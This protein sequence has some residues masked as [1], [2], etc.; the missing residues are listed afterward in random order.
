VKVETRSVS[1]I[2]TA[3]TP[4]STVVGAFADHSK[5][6]IFFSSTNRDGIA[7]AESANGQDFKISKSKMKLQ[8]FRRIH[9]STLDIGRI[10]I[11]ELKTGGLKI[12]VTKDLKKWTTLCRLEEPIASSGVVVSEFQ[13]NSC[14]L[15]YLGG[16]AIRIAT[17]PDAKSW[18][19]DTYPTVDIQ[20]KNNERI[21]IDFAEKL[22][23]GILV[24]YRLISYSNADTEKLQHQV[25]LVLLDS[26]FP[27]QI[28]WHSIQPI[29]ENNHHKSIISGSVIFRSQLYGFWNHTEVGVDLVRYQTENLPFELPRDRLVSLAKARSN[30]ILYPRENYRWESFATYNPAA[31]QIN[32]K[33]HILYRAQGHDLISSIGYASSSDGVQIDERLSTPV[34]YP[35]EVFESFQKLSSTDA[36]KKF[37]SGGGIAGCEDPRVSVIDNRVYMTYVAFDGASPPRIALTSIQL[38]DF[39][40]KRWLWKKPVL[41]SPP[42]VVDK[43]A[44]IFPEK[45]RGK[46]VIMHRI[47]PNIL[48]DYVSDLNFDGSYWLKEQDHIPIREG[49][50]DSRKVGAGAPPIKTPEGWLLIYYGVDDRDDRFYKMGAMLLD[51]ENPAKVLYRSSTPIL[52]PEEWYE[53]SGFKPG[54]VYPCGAVVLKE[55][56]LVYYGGADCVVCVASADLTEFIMALKANQEFKLHGLKTQRIQNHA[57]HQI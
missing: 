40:D 4:T 28:V 9:F 1:K 46:Y 16:T 27:N 55:K 52:E 30:P 20:V 39:L 51:L 22:P 12:S 53:N 42:G 48:I 8:S 31:F 10:A 21:E 29:S 34:Y 49:M 45:I 17:S 19:T 33:V 13:L 6:Y 47:F 24:C 44:V 32:H 3:K 56:L 36:A 25:Y 26:F 35:Q 11:T 37:M 2:K 15:M 7:M 54:V 43:S 57:T 50:W 18:K 41:I 5:L 38:N 23:H 14:Y